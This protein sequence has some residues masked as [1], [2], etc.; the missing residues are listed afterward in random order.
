MQRSI[1]IN[2]FFS[3]SQREIIQLEKK[4]LQANLQIVAKYFLQLKIPESS[5][6]SSHFQ[7]LISVCKRLKTASFIFFLHICDLL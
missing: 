3:K 4:S 7:T 2:S 6:L 1:H 5:S